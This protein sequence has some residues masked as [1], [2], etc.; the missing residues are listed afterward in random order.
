M[1]TKEMTRETILT[2]VE[3]GATTIT[4]VVRRLG[5]KSVCGGTTKRIR[6][7]VPDIGDRLKAAKDGAKRL[8]LKKV[9]K[10]KTKPAKAKGG[11]R[12][13]APAEY[14]RAEHNPFRAGSSMYG[15]CYDILAAHPDGIPRDKLVNELARLMP[16]K[17]GESDADLHR[18]AYYNVTVVASSRESG[19]SHRCIA[20]AADT[21]F[22]ARCENGGSRLRLVLRDRRY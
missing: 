16:R 15:I 20:R 22:V 10:K 19:E 18:R 8:A 21:Y 17:E 11:P 9:A 2:V 7:L 1:R 4:E 12:K 5:Y 6:E 3:A 13:G 14:F